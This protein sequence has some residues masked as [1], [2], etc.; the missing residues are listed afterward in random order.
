[1][2]GK[3][4]AALL[5]GLVCPGAGQI[6]N[7]QYVKGIALVI[8]AVGLIAAFIYE[9]WDAMVKVVASMPPDEVMGDLFGISHRLIEENGAAFSG[10]IYALIAVW[11]IAI[12]DAYV[13][14]DT[15]SPPL[16]GGDEGEGNKD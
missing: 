2:N 12:V 4:K 15:K 9:L 13:K 7:R 6:Y 14:G 11:V 5:S 10:I 1:M 16:R 3:M 8:A